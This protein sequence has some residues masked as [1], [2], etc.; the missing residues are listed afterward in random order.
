MQI[1]YLHGFNSSHRSFN[2]IQACLPE[3][4]VIAINYDSHQP[5]RDSM[6]QVRKQ[7][8]KGNFSLVGHSLGGILAVLMAAEHV[9]RT[10]KLITISSP[11]AGSRAAGA[12]RWIPGHPKIMHDIMPTSEKIMLISQLKLQVPT[13]SVISTGGNLTTT[14]QANDSVVTVE[15]QKALS[16]GRKQEVKANH[17]EVL[18]HEKTVKIIQDFLFKDAA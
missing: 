3:H 11:L 15:S 10:E 9:D 1:A 12:F 18:M 7:L 17:F 14:S 6:L 16:F 8:P 2:Y 13:T 4:E 5:L